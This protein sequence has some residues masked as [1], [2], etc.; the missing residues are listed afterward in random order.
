MASLQPIRRTNSLAISIAIIVPTILC[1]ACGSFSQAEQSQVVNVEPA[2]VTNVV[3]FGR[4]LP[5]GEVISLS[6]ANAEDSR[7]NKILVEEGDWVEAGQIVAV[8]Q[9]Y[10]RKMGDLEEAKQNVVLQEAK[11]KK[12]K[13]GDAKKSEIAAQQA[14]IDGLKAQLRYETQ[15]KEAAL[16]SVKAELEQTKLSFGRKDSLQRQGAISQEEADQ[17]REE[18]QVATAVLNQRQAELNN[19]IGTLEKQIIQEKKNLAKLKEVRPVDIE[20]AE[21]ELEMAQIAVKQHQADVEDTQVRV[22]VAGRILRIN[23]RV[24]ERVDTEEGII[25]LG[26][27]SQMYAIAE[28]YETEITKIEL[29][30]KAVIESEYGGFEGKIAGE[31]THIGLQV[32]KK[33]LTANSADPNT[34]ENARVVEIK[35]RI[36]DKDSKKVANLTNMQ[37]QV[38]INTEEKSAKIRK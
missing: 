19:T 12:I 25:E 37:V 7:V 29:G 14:V 33:T 2:P 31:V 10:E 36:N 32:G 18:F 8:L 21:A 1:N 9:G 23:T 24:G 17:A 30:Q 20:I 13:S 5:E 11:L 34:D 26:Q 28:V 22:P 3:A 15:A 6:V 27:T 38:I 4:L 16:N 35:I